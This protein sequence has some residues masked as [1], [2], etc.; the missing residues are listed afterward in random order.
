MRRAEAAVR[1]IVQ[2]S[3][4][5]I[6]SLVFGLTPFLPLRVMDAETRLQYTR[7]AGYVLYGDFSPF[8]LIYQRCQT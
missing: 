7:L 6:S 8:L 5:L 2:S 3:D 1:R 4:P